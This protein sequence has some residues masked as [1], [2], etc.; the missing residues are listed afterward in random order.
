MKQA[1]RTTK[2]KRMLC[3]AATK[4]VRALWRSA[5]IAISDAPPMAPA[6]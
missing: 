6:K 4:S 3:D 5:M 1:C 2:T